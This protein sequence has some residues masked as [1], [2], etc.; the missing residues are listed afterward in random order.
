MHGLQSADW[1][2]APSPG[3]VSALPLAS[4]STSA[5]GTSSK[6]PAL[7]R[8]VGKPR[9]RSMR[10]SS[11]LSSRSAG[12]GTGFPASCS[13]AFSEGS[14]LIAV[15]ALAACRL[16]RHERPGRS[17]VRWLGAQ[18]GSPLDKAYVNH[19]GSCPSS[20][21]CMHAAAKSQGDMPV[22]VLTL[23]LMPWH[24]TADDSFR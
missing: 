7:S 21:P 9:R 15:A 23:V 19:E 24:A 14:L 11:V 5:L 13:A 4:A 8:R 6:P 18:T 1:V 20:W 3:A 22:P 2:S 16:I 10:P 17:Y 12:W